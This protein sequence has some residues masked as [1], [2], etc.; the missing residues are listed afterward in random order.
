M[1]LNYSVCTVRD[2]VK[3]INVLGLGLLT[4]ANPRHFVVTVR[5]HMKQRIV[6][7]KMNLLFVTTVG[8]LEAIFHIQYSTARSILFFREEDSWIK[9]KISTIKYSQRSSF[10]I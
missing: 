3:V 5:G 4:N 10:T 9:P 6:L 1:F 7:K 2:Y 8:L